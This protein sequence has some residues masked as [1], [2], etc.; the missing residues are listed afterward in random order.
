MKRHSALLGRLL[1]LALL[2]LGLVVIDRVLTEYRY[3]DVLA[4]VRLLPWPAIAASVVLT[5]LGYLTLVGYDWLAF[6]HVGFPR[7]YWQMLVPS[8][9]SIAVANNAPASVVTGG[10]IRYRLYAPLGLTAAQATGVAG[11][12]VLTYAIGLC[13]LGGGAVLVTGEGITGPLTWRGLHALAIGALVGAGA[14]LVLAWWRPGPLAAGRVSLRIPDRTTVR[15]QLVL[16]LAD[17]LLS[18]AALFVLLRSVIRIPYEAFLALFLLA[19]FS[20]LILPVPGGVGVF[21]AVVLLLRPRE[22]HAPTVLAALLVYRVVYYLLPLLAA[23]VA[24]LVSRMRP[25]HH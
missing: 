3:H 10:G 6:R 13:L 25:A 21:E 9:I 15:I 4:A 16:S 1:A 24:Y 18:S 20:T 23:G 2:A 17:W 5:V 8:L 12:N 11:F 22:A 14:Y 7:P 19:Q